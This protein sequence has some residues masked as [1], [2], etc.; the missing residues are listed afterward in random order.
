M[1]APLLPQGTLDFTGLSRQEMLVRLQTL[2][3]QVN[4]EWDDF[5]AAFPENLLLEGMVFQSD[6][7]R[8]V[9]EE[10]VR[11]RGGLT[12]LEPGYTLPLRGV[13]HDI[14]HVASRRGVVTVD[15]ACGLIHVPGEEAHVK[16]R[17]LDFL[18]SAAREDLTRA[19]E[20]YAALM[21]VSYR[22]ITI[23]D[24]RSRWGSCSASGDL[25]YSW[26]L[27]LAPGYVLD[28]VAAHEVA[29]L[30]HL[31][32]SPRFW[33]LVLTHCPNAAR[34]KNWLRTNGQNVHRVVK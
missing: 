18:K 3:N 20:R 5:S 17:L 8:G 23:R 13:P 34:A 4:P 25:S 2:F 29:H 16:R 19:S 33:R 26:R 7:M 31:D 15:A 10:R 21:G 6:I 1:P 27:I 24:Q 30:K 22:R 28:Y 12:H 32:H 11:Q 14:R 9:I